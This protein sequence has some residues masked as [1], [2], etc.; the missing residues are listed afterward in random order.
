MD[1]T[2][3]GHLGR[4][5]E[6]RSASSHQQQLDKTAADIQSTWQSVRP[7][8]IANGGTAEAQ[9]FDATVKQVQSTG[10]YGSKRR[11][12]PAGSPGA[13]GILPYSWLPLPNPLTWIGSARVSPS[14]LSTILFG[15]HPS[16][17]VFLTAS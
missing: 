1:V 12:I 8:V 10:Q 17:I 3:L 6:I 14:R 4:E 13:V 15:S 5:L 2:K 16:L 7:R 11:K 9:K